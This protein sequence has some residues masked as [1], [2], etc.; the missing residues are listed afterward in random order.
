MRPYV[1]NTFSSFIVACLMAMTPLS[2]SA[3]TSLEQ[4]RQNLIAAASA[5]PPAQQAVYIAQELVD[6]AQALVDSC[7]S[8][9][10]ALPMPSSIQLCTASIPPQCTPNPLP[11]YCGN[12]DDPQMIQANIAHLQGE[13]V[14]LM[15]ALQ[16]AEE[17]LANVE[18]N[19]TIALA[20]YNEI[21]TAK[22]VPAMGSIGLLALG[23]SMLGLGAVRLRKK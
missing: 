10:Q 4:A 17:H 3:S 22:N 16:N 8:S 20:D 19:F 15:Q 11:A 9:S 21:V 5:I 18:S 12:S 2:I 6:E 1:L 7:L 23:L 14:F 13:L